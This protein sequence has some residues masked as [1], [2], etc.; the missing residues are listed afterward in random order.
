MKSI[1]GKKQFSNIS[2]VNT[3][4][5][6][7]PH[8]QFKEPKMPPRSNLISIPPVN[9]GTSDV[10]SLTSYISRIAFEYVVSPI[11]LLKH[12]LIDRTKLPKNLIN[13][14]SIKFPRAINGMGE[15][16][17][18]IVNALQQVTLRNDIYFTT[19]L[20]WKGKLSQNNLFKPN[21]AWCSLC[22]SEQIK[23][24]GFNYEK[25][26]WSLEPVKKCR[27]HQI[28]L[29]NKCPH[30]NQLLAVFGGNFRSG[31]CSRCFM[32]L[33]NK[34][35]LYQK[36]ETSH[37]NSE[38]A[39]K[40]QC[41]EIIIKSALEKANLEKNRFI[42]N[43]ADIISQLAFGNINEFSHQVNIWHNNIRILLK[44][45]ILP[46]WEILSK[47]SL[48]TGVSIFDLLTT[49]RI[50]VSKN[51]EYE[52]YLSAKKSNTKQPLITYQEGDEKVKRT[53]ETYSSQY[54]PLS[55]SEIARRV[56]YS[57]SDRLKSKYPILYKEIVDN[58]L[59]YIESKKTPL[60]D[61][62]VE[63]LLIKASQEVPPPSLQSVFRRLGCRNTG[64][65]YYDRF[66][67]LCLLIAQ[68]YKR[69]V[70][71]L[72]DRK[73]VENILIEALKETPPPSLSELARRLKCKR[74]SLKRIFPELVSEL[75]NKRKDFLSFEKKTQII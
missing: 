35:C 48:F 27:K 12:G 2:E 3:E 54:P 28:S 53:I 46:T 57:S 58:Y 22:F 63:R 45:N 65:L 33:G 62:D 73:K 8:W 20:G 11:I 5:E 75:I 36:K 60:P 72:F 41:E 23:E 67:E 49:P 31:Y 70:S 61:E 25:L 16:T 29:E 66:P 47:I 9:I 13:S 34:D 37:M 38:E 17:Q 52:K 24:M 30:C 43:L 10:E 1:S 68:R 56:G 44:G 64:Y 26:L 4:I 6:N 51:S 40:S 42:H 69:S 55:A 15:T 71:Q 7:Y 74:E 50:E 18:N 19:L 39:T 21:R 59:Y 14:D 32:W